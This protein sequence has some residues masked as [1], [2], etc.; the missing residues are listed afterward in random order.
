MDSIETL[1]MNSQIVGQRAQSHG[2]M[3]YV[4]SKILQVLVYSGKSQ[5][6]KIVCLVKAGCMQQC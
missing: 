3:Y 1:I 4:L 5:R 2:N 6:Y